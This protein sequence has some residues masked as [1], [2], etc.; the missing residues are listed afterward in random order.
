[1]SLYSEINVHFLLSFILFIAVCW[2]NL[3]YC[4]LPETDYFRR[5]NLYLWTQMK[6][7]IFST[8]LKQLTPEK[9]LI[10]RKEKTGCVSCTT[11]HLTPG[12]DTAYCMCRTCCSLLAPVFA[13]MSSPYSYSSGTTPSAHS[14]GKDSHVPERKLLLLLPVFSGLCC[15]KVGCQE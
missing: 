1:M 2:I 6:K 3:N 10:T 13:N 8:S 4:P 15:K 12:L 14:P 11:A 9:Q 7:L 5:C